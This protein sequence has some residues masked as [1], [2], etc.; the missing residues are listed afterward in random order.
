[1]LY[2]KKHI[3]VVL[4]LLI[5]FFVT[6]CSVKLY[7]K[8]TT[9]SERVKIIQKNI[10]TFFYDSTTNLFREATIKGKDD[11][12]YS[13]LW[14]LCALI[15]A[16]NETEVVQPGTLSMNSVV[17]AIDQYYSKKPPAP[18]YEAY[19]VQH[20]GDS[21]FYDDNQWIGIAFIDAYARTGTTAYLNRAE[22]IYRF[23][24]TGYSTEAGGGLYWK[25]HD[26]TTKNTCSNGP[27]IVLAL[28]LYKATKQQYYLD[29]ALALY[30]WTNQYLQSPQGIYF[31]HIKL[32]SLEIDKRFYTYN[33][34]TMLESNI[35]L[36][37]ITGDEKYL[38]IAKNLAA[39]S[40][41]HFYKNGRFPDHYWFNAVLLRGYIA[42]SRH[43]SDTTYMNVIKSDV[44]NIWNKE[45]DSNHL[46]GKHKRKE[47]IS[48]AAMLEIYA[49]LAAF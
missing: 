30:K 3:D 20:G 45:K 22:E 11:K 39:A 15:Q 19:P 40:L 7:N 38:I 4:L 31:D 29:T 44:E 48:Q 43:D 41:Q 23:M 2:I 10:Y 34:G 49:R 8:K 35:L 14:P 1:M 6:G 16:A 21:R 36:Y 24:L 46:L 37:E 12:A 26:L 42:L 13:Y 17:K 27:G 25:E 32:P 47:L 18:G 33:T 9:Y 5:C 28:K